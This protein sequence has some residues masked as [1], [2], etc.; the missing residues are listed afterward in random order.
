V[1]RTLVVNASP[2]ILFSR[3]N[4]LDLLTSLAKLLVVP[5]AVIREI[6]A[7]SHR[8]EAADRIKDL[9]ALSFSAAIEASS[10]QHALSSR[11]SARL[12]CA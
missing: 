4:R 5:E 11:R 1:D 2:L 9:W 6:Q 12:G 3:I 10:A 8:D 7:G